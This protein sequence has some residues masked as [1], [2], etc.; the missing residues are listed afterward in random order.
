MSNF[1]KLFANL[2]PRRAAQ[3]LNILR[4]AAFFVFTVFAFQVG[5]V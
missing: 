2:G 5:I 4:L 1:A 3:I